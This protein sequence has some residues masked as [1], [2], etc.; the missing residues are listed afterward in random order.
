M[1]HW[2]KHLTLDVKGCDKTRVTDPGYIS[3]FTKKL[4][5][6]IDMVPYGEPQ[7]VHFADGTEKAG[8]TVIQLIQTS[9]IMGH[10]LDING[11]LYLDVF[12]CKEFKEEIVIETLKEYFAPEQIQTNVIYRDARIGSKSTF[13][14]EGRIKT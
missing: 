7:L 8:W 6:R 11:D 9:N 14:V 4:V 10:F 1:N 5:Q 2:G 13:W 12:S 3:E